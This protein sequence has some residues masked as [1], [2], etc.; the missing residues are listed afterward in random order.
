MEKVHHYAPVLAIIGLGL[1]SM[2]QSSLGAAYGVIKARP[3][4]Y[5]PEMSVLFMFSALVGGIALTLFASMLASRLT[6]KARVNDVLVERVSGLL[7][8]LLVGYFYFRFWEPFAGTY[9]YEPGRSEGLDILTGGVLSFNFW[10]GEMLLGIFIPMV[11]LLYRKTRTNPFWR[12]V[13]LFLV[14]A[15]VVAYRWDTNL[16]GQLAVVSYWPGEASVSYASYHPSLV[17]WVTGLGI[18]AYGML[19]FSL[20]VKYLHVVDHALIEK[21]HAVIKENV[22]EAVPV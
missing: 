11:L 19:A 6:P 21:E 17:E 15:G 5:K 8:W 13:A 20:G 18:V 2:H 9:T 12:M 10:I 3:F 4:W 14:A 7:A 1:S 16:V 22:G